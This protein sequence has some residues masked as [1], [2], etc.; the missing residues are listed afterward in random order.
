MTSISRLGHARL[1][2]SSTRVSLRHLLLAG[3]I[4][5]AA[6][7][8]A[9]AP[10]LVKDIYPGVSSTATSPA[11]FEQILGVSNGK[12]FLSGG[13]VADQGLFVSDG[14]SAGTRMVIDVAPL[15]GADV[16]GTFFF[17]AVTQERGSLWKTDGTTA[18]TAF[19]GRFSPD[20]SVP[21]HPSRLTKV[22]SRLSF[23]VDD[24]I[25]GTELW[26]S[27]GTAAGTRM[28]KDVTPGPVGSFDSYS[29]F[30]DVG[31]TL[32]FSCGSTPGCGLWKSDGTDAGTVPLA[33][34]ESVSSLV[35]LSGTLESVFILTPPHSSRRRAEP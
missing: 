12:A 7:A 5:A 20:P 22:G 26:T 28:V 21:A 16:D 4:L 19:V 14:T 10:A 32:F 29:S 35:N 25:H 27:D 30:A 2:F 23:V 33:N 8:S 13:D 18:G 34:L 11:S 9:Q 24:G 6:G 31:D 3:S 15:G 1:G 17:G